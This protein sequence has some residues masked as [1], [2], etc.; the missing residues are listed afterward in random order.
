[1]LVRHLT[2]A[3]GLLALLAQDDPT[4][5]QLRAELELDGRVPSRRTW[6]RRLARL[7]TRLPDLIGALGSDLVRLLEP[8][9]ESGERG[10]D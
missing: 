5:R 3:T 7:P 2:C 4:I 6:E 9:V 8:W 1:M 10:G